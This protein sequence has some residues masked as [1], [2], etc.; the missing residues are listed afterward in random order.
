MI[1][2]AHPCPTES[3]GVGTE[4]LDKL[5]NRTAEVSQSRK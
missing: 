1:Q 2:R 5:N 3:A 4:N